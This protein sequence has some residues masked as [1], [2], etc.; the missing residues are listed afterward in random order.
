MASVLFTRKIQII[1]DSMNPEK[2]SEVLYKFFLQRAGGASG[3]KY[4]LLGLIIDPSTL[5]LFSYS[6]LPLDDYKL[7]PASSILNFQPERK[8][9]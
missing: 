1:P 3:P 8:T 2:T 4:F 9:S 5:P 7:R 6:H